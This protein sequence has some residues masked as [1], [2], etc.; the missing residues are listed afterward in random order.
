MVVTTHLFLYFQVLSS[1]AVFVIHSSTFLL[2]YGIIEEAIDWMTFL[3]I[4][5]T[6]IIWGVIHLGQVVFEE[7]PVERIEQRREEPRPPDAADAER[8]DD[9]WAFLKT[10]KDGVTASELQHRELVMAEF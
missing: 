6:L 5:F 3:T 9:R 8:S 10:K 2:F 4:A 1:A 7:I